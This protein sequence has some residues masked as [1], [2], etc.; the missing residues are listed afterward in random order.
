MSTIGL[1]TILA[2]GTCDVT[3]AQ[4]GDATYVAAASVTRTI[5]IKAGLP[6]IP[7]LMSASPEDSSLI[8]A[9]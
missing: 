2:P 3:A 6:G 1:V 5:T 7:H 9:Y 8:V 4:A